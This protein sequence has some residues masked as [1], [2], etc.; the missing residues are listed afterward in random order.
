M[1]RG[2]ADIL[3]VLPLRAGVLFPGIGAPFV[4]GRDGSL[5]A[6][7]AALAREDKDLVVCGQRTSEGEPRGLADLSAVG[8]RGHIRS[9][10]RGPESV[11]VVIHG[12]E[13][14]A[15]DSVLSS[16]PG[17]FA[18]VRPMPMRVDEGTDVEA[19]SREVSGLVHK[20]VQLAK[21]SE[22]PSIDALLR[23]DEDRVRFV[24]TVASLLDVEPTFGRELLEQSSVGDALRLLV[25][26]LAREV[27]ILEVRR[28]I[29]ERVATQMDKE[30]REYVLRKQLKT[31]Q[32]ELGDGDGEAAE[33]SE[34]TQ[35][36]AQA[37][38]P[39]HARK[40][41]EREVARL[42]RMSPASHEHQVIRGY[43]E[44]VLELP[45]SAA[46]E[47][48]VDLP[49]A[50]AVLDSDHHG[51]EDVKQRL[52]EHLAVL[53][54][55]PAAKAPILCFVG[56]PGVGKTSL[57]QSIARAL[58]RRFERMSLGG[59]H[60]EAELRGHRR[61]YVGAMP[62]R[63]LQAIRRSGVRNPLLM[64]DEVDK[65]GRDFRGDPAAALLEIL[66]PEQNHQF[67]DNYL[68]IPFDLSHVMFIT[69]A[70]F[71][72]AI[73]Q[74]L[75]DRMEV[76]RLSGY[77]E[78]EK[79]QIA[80]RYLLPRQRER[81]GIAAERFALEDGVVRH[82]VRRYTREAGV[83]QLERVIARLVRKAAVGFAEGRGEPVKVR[84]EDLPSML[85][86]EPFF[87][88]ELRESL[89]VG[90]A[91]GLAWTEVGGVLLYVESALLPGR[92]E[93]TLT[94]QLG[95]VMQESA[96][97]ALTCVW[98]RRDELGIAPERVREFGAHVHVPAGAVP[99]D[100]PSAGVTVATALASVYTGLP[101]RRDTAMTG[102]VTISGLVLPVGGIKEKLLAARRA[103]IRRVVIPRGNAKDLRD[104]DDRVLAALDVLFADVVEDAWAAAI[105][106]LGARLPAGVAIDGGRP[107]SVTVAASALTPTEGASIERTA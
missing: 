51:L 60:D 96:R 16:G 105:P 29:I 47:V 10:Q 7:D 53:A 33:A 15:I 54:L 42:E 71:S 78:E 21:G 38:L 64:L 58:G 82:L 41:A 20:L 97:A 107:T 52:V 84:V 81:A 80:A 31:I 75:L 39:E 74:P 72:E 2:T 89:G 37:G 100:G 30:Q 62:G 40:E 26:H 93:L 45:W 35:R 91:P 92:T 106:G 12:I 50:R 23:P 61:T 18:S 27:Q 70:N 94:G 68:E 24:F 34:L 19:L 102:E 22:L 14:V 5:A 65:L 36:I 43:L 76:V 90:V 32:D 8:V 67:R 1:A 6:V 101:A 86:P 63:I 79:E 49:A 28:E 69:T 88:D 9:L 46:T 83:R 59:V 85:G 13:R 103:G 4:V 44:F 73:P 104:I 3:P 11:T 57:G 87:G 55:N 56:P 17:L 95:E 77:G 25:K 98:S 99:K 66:D 48:K